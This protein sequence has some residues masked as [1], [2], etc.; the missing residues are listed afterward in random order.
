METNIER[1]EIKLIVVDET[2]SPLLKKI[3]AQINNYLLKNQSAASDFNIIH[4]VVE[5]NC[6]AADEEISQKL[7][8]PLYL[9]LMGT[10]L[11]IIIG[12]FSLGSDVMSTGFVASI[13]NLLWSIKFAMICSFVGL[14]STTLLTAWRYRSAKAKVEDE[15]NRFYSFVQAEIMP[16]MTENA[17]STIMTMQQNLQE[18]N[19]TFGT[20]VTEFHG[21]MDKIKETFDSQVELVQQLKDMDIA[22][23]A[24]LDANVLKELHKS[25]RQFQQFTQYLHEMN[26]FVLNTTRLNDTVT[27]QLQRTNALE[28]VITEMRQQIENNRQIMEMLR[29]FL[30]Q[31]D[32]D[33]ALKHS[34]AELDNTLTEA[35]N[36]IRT[37][38][39]SQITELQAYTTRATAQ[40]GQLVTSLSGNGRDAQQKQDINVTTDNSDVV[41]AIGRLQNGLIQEANKKWEAQQKDLRKGFYIIS[42]MLVISISLSVATC[43]NSVPHNQGTQ[44]ANVDAYD[45]A[46]VDSAVVDSTDSA[47]SDTVATD[48]AAVALPIN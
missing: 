19:R 36:G 12:L 8:V 7:P 37:H 48:S 45:S 20:N 22:Q 15:K 1:V 16:V 3:V 5:R 33:D 38:I 28:S 24:N 29:N 35:V 46:A 30:V 42:A 44:P 14:L 40:L 26:D 21:I 25:M 4:D 34:S 13:G 47:Y 32:T 9:G 31:V 6:D 39:Q 17:A 23:I 43:Y 11:G 27:Q 18:F 2:A 10:V 41:S